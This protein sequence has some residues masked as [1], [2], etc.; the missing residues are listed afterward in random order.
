V[1]RYRGSTLKT[2]AKGA[3]K[4]TSIYHYTLFRDRIILEFREGEEYTYSYE[5]TG[6]DVVEHM[7]SLAKSGAGLNRFLNLYKPGYMLGSFPPDLDPTQIDGDYS[8]D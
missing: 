5:S 4:K 8:G 1:T 3:S 2:H 6:E 7:R